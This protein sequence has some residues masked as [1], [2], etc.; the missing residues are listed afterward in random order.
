LFF[1]LLQ[2]SNPLLVPY[3]DISE[4][5]IHTAYDLFCKNMHEAGMTLNVIMH[6][7]TARKVFK[8]LDPSFHLD[9]QVLRQTDVY[10]LFNSSLNIV[11]IFNSCPEDFVFFIPTAE[12]YSAFPITQDITSLPADDP[13]KLLLGWVIFEDIGMA[14][15][16]TGELGYSHIVCKKMKTET[17]TPHLVT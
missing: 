15:I 5:T 2:E 14:I 4:H 1:R 17:N 10:K 16:P 13:R 3:C 7:D 6:P 9:D 11:H 8:T 12:Y